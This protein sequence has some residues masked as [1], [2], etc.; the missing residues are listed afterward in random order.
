M[1]PLGQW[2]QY[3]NEIS[4]ILFILILKVRKDYSRDQSRK[5]TFSGELISGPIGHIDSGLKG[6]HTGDMIAA[7]PYSVFGLEGVFGFIV[8]GTKVRNKEAF[9]KIVSDLSINT[10]FSLTCTTRFHAIKLIP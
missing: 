9:I 6:Q 4:L 8:Q 10:W 1:V 3:Y 5:R 2:S 7:V